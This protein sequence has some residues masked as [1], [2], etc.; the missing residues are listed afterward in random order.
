LSN[1]KKNSVELQ[2]QCLNAVNIQRLD[3][4]T[5][6]QLDGSCSKT[7]IDCSVDSCQLDSVDV[8]QQRRLATN[9]LSLLRSSSQADS[10][11]KIEIILAVVFSLIATMA[12]AA[13][14]IVIYRYK[15]GKSL[16]CCDC[17]QL[18]AT[19]TTSTAA[20]NAAA[21]KKANHRDLQYHRHMINRNP[22]VIE[23][24]VTHGANMNL[25]S[26]GN[27]NHAYAQENGSNTKRKLYNPMFADSPKSDNRHNQHAIVE[28]NDTY[29]SH[30]QI[31][32]EN[33]G[34]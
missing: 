23:S 34:H 26:H 4:L 13:F 31:H 24:I 21:T 18:K 27:Q 19:T 14:I 28:S 3:S 10:N 22:T 15:K 5:D 17:L 8:E 12:F 30:H 32:S 9:E 11:R 33:Q 6:Q 2:G 16:L 25:P 29:S 1:A 7:S 20:A